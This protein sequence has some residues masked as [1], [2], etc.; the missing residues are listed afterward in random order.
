MDPKF[1][2]D[3]SKGQKLSLKMR[4]P[5]ACTNFSK[6]NG[7][8]EHPSILTIHYII[9]HNIKEI[10]RFRTWFGGRTNFIIFPI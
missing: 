9:K 5:S 8:D 1:G 10:I 7:D 2:K 6:F 3:M 4:R